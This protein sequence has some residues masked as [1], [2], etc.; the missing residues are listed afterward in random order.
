MFPIDFGVN[1]IKV[2]ATMGGSMSC[3]TNRLLYHYGYLRLVICKK[4]LGLY[5]SQIQSFNNPSERCLFKTLRKWGKMLAI[6]N[7]FVFPQSCLLFHTVPFF[8]E[9]FILLSVNA[10]NLDKSKILWLGKELRNLFGVRWRRQA[11][12]D[13]FITSAG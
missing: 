9:T 6:H 11:G 12:S 13:P 5:Q 10:L 3:F 2:K 4:A 1:Q 8:S 7:F